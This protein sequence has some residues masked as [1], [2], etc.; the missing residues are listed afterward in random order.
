MWFL[1]PM[2]SEEG[3]AEAAVEDG[4]GRSS[5]AN[6]REIFDLC[7]GD[8]DGYITALDFRSIGKEHFGNTQVFN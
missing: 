1:D 3:R 6:L 2:A 4:H 7:D 8:K 5:E